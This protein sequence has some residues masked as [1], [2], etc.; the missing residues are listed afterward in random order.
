MT[1]KLHTTT[2]PLTPISV[3]IMPKIDWQRQVVTS[4]PG[5]GKQHVKEYGWDGELLREYDEKA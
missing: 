1:R 4:M 2:L 5:T 3:M